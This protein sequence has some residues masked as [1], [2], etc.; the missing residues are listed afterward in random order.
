V[1]VLHFLEGMHALLSS[2]NELMEGFEL[3]KCFLVRFIDVYWG[4]V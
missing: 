1:N 2:D 4:S 3:N